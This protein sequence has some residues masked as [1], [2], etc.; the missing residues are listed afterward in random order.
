[1]ISEAILMIAVIVAASMVTQM[2]VV[3]LARIQYSSS[4]AAKDLSEKMRTSIQII[5]AFNSSPTQITLWVKNTGSAS[6]TPQLVKMSDLLLLG[7]SSASEYSYS[8]A[9]HGWS[10]KLL[11]SEDSEW[12]Y[13]ETIEVKLNL[14]DVLATGDYKV[15]FIVYNGVKSEYSFTVG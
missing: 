8:E 9:G 14:T 13:G 3:S 6:F 1:M 4:W 15:I 7:P 11:N 12:D 5:Y 10:F 2:F